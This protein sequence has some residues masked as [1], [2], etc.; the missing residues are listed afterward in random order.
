MLAAAATA[1]AALTA[2]GVAG[3]QTDPDRTAGAPQALPTVRFDGI[4]PL[5]LGMSRRAALRTGWLADRD[6]GCKLGGRPFP[7]VYRLTGPNAPKGVD[8]LVEF[9]RNRLQTLTFQRGVRTANGVVVG[10]TTARGMANRYRAGG[11]AVSVQYEPIFRGTFVMVRRGRRE[12]IGGFAR[13]RARARK[14]ISILAVPYV[15]TCE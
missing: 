11:Y 1:V 9:R 2:G 7:L 6:I 14:P 8:G 5:R 13:G 3:A 4:G 15:T 10:R 12:L